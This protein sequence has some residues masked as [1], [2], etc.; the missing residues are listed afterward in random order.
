L[1]AG[2]PVPE[3]GSL[4][5]AALGISLPEPLGRGSDGPAPDFP[6]QR[7]GLIRLDA[8]DQVLIDAREGM[9]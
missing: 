3:A 2:V 6:L 1:E 8:Y 7:L 4:S 9:R 5:A